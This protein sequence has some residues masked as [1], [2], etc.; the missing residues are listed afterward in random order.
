MHPNIEKAWV[1]IELG[2]YDQARSLLAEVLAADPDDLT[3]LTAMAQVALQLGDPLRALEYCSAAQRFA[4]DYAALWRIRALAELR[5]SE[6][7]DQE[8]PLARRA[9]A[10]NSALVAVE[11]DPE[12]ADN[13]RV[14]AVTQR[15]DEPEAALDSLDRA[16]VIEPERADLHLLRGIVLRRNLSAPDSVDRAERALRR[17]LE[18]EP[19]YVDAVLELAL[20]DLDRREFDSAT[21]R[22][23]QAAQLEPRH[24]E[25]VRET[26]TWIEDQRQQWA[27]AL[28]WEPDEDESHRRTVRSLHDQAQ[29]EAD[30]AERES[31]EAAELE[32]VL[33]A[34]RS[35]F[36]EP[37]PSPEPA[38]RGRGSARSRPVELDRPRAGAGGGIAALVVAFL[39][40]AVIRGAI[41]SD[42]AGP[43]S[44]YTPPPTVPAW[45]L[46]PTDIR[47][48]PTYQRP[49]LPSNWPSLLQ[50]PTYAPVRPP[51]TPTLPPV[52]LPPGFSPYGG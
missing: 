26:L 28:H 50:R 23:R 52:T 2:R 32:R 40:I 27:A 5:A 25:A 37:D 10:Q 14:L 48:P 20:V 41:G 42:G 7:E 35:D 44:R 51:A 1:L 3:A 34:M 43:G 15:E 17:A 45:Y 19:E 18:L 21:A 4:P 36:P 31:R 8:S 39:V 6:D 16:L 11:L 13:H 22:L 46:G 47:V 29:A 9:A 38:G 24:A 30:A 33:R 49:A 12:D